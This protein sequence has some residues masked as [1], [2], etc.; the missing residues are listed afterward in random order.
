MEKLTRRLFLGKSAAAGVVGA[1]IVVPAVAEAKAEMTAKERF[2]Y[3]LAEFKK[4]AEELDPSIGKWNL[5]QTADPELGCCV[6]ISA[7][8][9]TGR[10]EGDGTYQSGT[11]NVFGNYGKWRVQLRD[12][13][14]DGFRT[15]S[16]CN[17]M[18]RMVLTEPALNTTIGR[19]LA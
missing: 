16:V 11:P 14:I 5:R 13:K 3:H 1:A 19:R 15:F 9:I 10:Y 18:D 2:D 7:H 6:L 12:E 8:R 17:D 4:A